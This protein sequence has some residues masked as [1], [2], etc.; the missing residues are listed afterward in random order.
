MC[1]CARD[2]EGSYA[3]V[4]H[5]SDIWGSPDFRLDN[6]RRPIQLAPHGGIVPDRRSVD[7]YP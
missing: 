7:T 4:A 6:G 5:P 3:Q 1:E 2:S